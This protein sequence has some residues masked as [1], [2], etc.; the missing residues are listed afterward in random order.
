MSVVAKLLIFVLGLGVGVGFIKYSY[1]LTQL[2]G[3][4]SYAEQYIGSGGTYSMWKL[5]GLAAI[6][7]TIWWVF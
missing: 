2:F 4:N 7:G 1:Q 5:L 3:H 6:L